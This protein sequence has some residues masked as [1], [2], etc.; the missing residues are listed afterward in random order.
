[1]DNHRP[2]TSAKPVAATTLPG[3]SA[4][5][6]ARAAAAPEAATPEAE[7]LLSTL[8]QRV[9]SESPVDAVQVRRLS[10]EIRSG[11]YRCDPERIAEKLIGM[12]LFLP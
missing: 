2:K 3:E 5:R 8:V 9:L 4:R 10:D 7:A 12:E 1:M 6:H 11:N